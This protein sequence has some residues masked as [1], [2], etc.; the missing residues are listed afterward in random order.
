[1]LPRMRNQALI[2][3]L[4]ALLPLA[5]CKKDAP[6]PEKTEP[7]AES[8]KE[9][10]A[11]KDPTVASAGAVTGVDPGAQIPETPTE[12]NARNLER[13]R[14][15]AGVVSLLLE[16][17]H[18]QR[19]T[20][21]DAI[22]TKGFDALLE[23]MDPGRLFL[24]QKHVD[25][26]RGSSD[27]LD[28]QL[29]AGKLDL[30][31]EAGQLLEKRFRVVAKVIDEHLAR[32]PNLDDEEHIETDG[33]KRSWCKTEA[34]LSDRWRRVLEH[35]YLSRLEQLREA[36]EARAKEGTP[37]KDD[38]S[39][40]ER[41]LERLKETYS[42]RFDRLQ[43]QKQ[44]D[45]LETF[46][47]A[48]ASAYDPH[49]LWLPPKEKQDFDIRMTGR[50]EGIGAVLS[51]DGY[52]IKVVRIVPGSA[53]W[54]QGK[55]KADD[56]ILAVAQGDE[57]PVDVVGMR[58]GDA[59]QLI[60]G[61]KGTTVRLTVR[62]QD[63]ATTIIPIVRDVVRIETAYAR[64]AVLT[65]PKAAGK[66]GYIDVPSFYGDRRGGG[67]ERTSSGDVERLLKAFEGQE[68]GAVILDLRSNGGGFLE[69]A[70]KMA[71]LFF[72]KGPVVQTKA[73]SG[74]IE[75]LKDEDPRVVW[76]GPLIVMVDKF[77]ASAS[78][79]VA[80]ALQDYGRAVIVGSAEQTH[81]KGTVQTLV[82]L[83]RLVPSEL[84]KEGIVPLGVMKI[85]QQQY[86]RV[87]GGSVQRKGITPDLVLPDPVAHMETGERSYDTALP[88]DELVARPFPE[89]KKGPKPDLS[90]LR[91]ASDERVGKEVAFARVRARS[92]LL[93]KRTKD[94]V[95]PTQKT[96]WETRSKSMDDALKALED[97]EDAPKRFAATLVR[98]AERNT[99][100]KEGDKDPLVEWVDDLRTDPWVE[101]TL[102]VL[103]DIH[104]QT[105]TSR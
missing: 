69:D 72:E 59:V 95:W 1:M 2:L 86:Y 41:A 79:I 5:S 71:G 19:K 93:E 10:P 103:A 43:Q 17:R 20:P 80:G 64:G 68:V 70:R 22:S 81:G 82:N 97:P 75:V 77:S 38:R 94:T 12:D 73:F 4:G 15:L 33:E 37:A 36:D 29:N 53:S 48:L 6:A 3:V 18:V 58:L 98:Y 87:T 60:R 92:D 45:W 49:T 83:D 14:A 88:W 62:K 102:F 65:H 63:G 89:W 100:L 16:E 7:A 96:A 24:L 84:H 99:P 39:V 31:I 66:V 56:K 50:L 104:K 101:E 35:G 76:G 27:K 26:L 85:T 42:A 21:D 61:P 8:A 47:N 74:D 52:F 13:E 78:E 57:E 54:R 9:A 44:V 28:D 25:A 91:A 51:V 32:S 40:E 105:Q 67:R 46:I 55:L 11:E 90:A 30:A 23:R 34:D